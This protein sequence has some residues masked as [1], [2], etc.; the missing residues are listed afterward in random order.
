MKNKVL[1]V[2]AAVLLSAGIAFAFVSTGSSTCCAPQGSCE[3]AEQTCCD[4]PCPPDGCPPNC[5]EE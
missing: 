1:A 3:V 5:C 4:M 2:T